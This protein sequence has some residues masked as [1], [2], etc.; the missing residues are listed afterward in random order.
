MK[1][2]IFISLLLV[3]VGW[4]CKDDSFLNREPTNILIDNQVWKDPTLVLSVV[5]DLY[6]RIPEYQTIQ[7]WWNY[8]DFDEGFGSNSGDYWRHKN[9]DWGLAMVVVELRLYPGN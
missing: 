2:Y 1:K 7:N 8:A 6:D 9:N 4:S 5:A 3:T